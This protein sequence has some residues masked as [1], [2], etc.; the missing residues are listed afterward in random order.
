MSKKESTPGRAN[1]LMV[2][3]VLMAA[4]CGARPTTAS[5]PDAP[6]V[7]PA[8]AAPTVAAP[9]VPPQVPGFNY[10]DPAQVCH[11]FV[12]ALYSGD[13]TRD[14]GP[15]DAFVRASAYTSGA[16]AG[17]GA[18]ARDGRWETW[19][20]HRARLDV[21][22][23]EHVDMHPEPDSSI[24]AYRAVQ[25]TATPIGDLGW[26]GWTERSIVHC[27]LRPADGG[28]PGWRVAHYNV[29]PVRP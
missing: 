15:R 13:T 12:A 4:G 23:F 26:R 20:R 2:A 7:K 22:V 1:A 11:R 19:V 25:L 16:L 6:A 9:V 17:Q 8:I 5:R 14:A 10:R 29:E 28:Q 27:T 21:Q 3:V 18:A 24:A